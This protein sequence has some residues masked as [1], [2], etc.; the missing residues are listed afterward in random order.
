MLDALVR[1]FLYYPEPLPR[2]ARVP[3]YCGP[4]RE[5]WLSSALGDEINALYWEPPPGRPVLL[6]LHG[7]AQCIHEWALVREDL[8]GTETGMLLLDYP[9]YGKSTGQPREEG[10]YAAGRAG[11]EWLLERWP[12]RLVVVF[13]KSL[14]GGVAT[15]VAQDADLGALVLESTFTS[16]PAVARRL[17]PFLPEGAFPD[18]ERYDSLSKIGK[19]RCP[20]LVIHGTEDELIPFEQGRRLYEAA[21]QPKEFF[22][23]EGAGHNNVALVAG[24][25]YASRLRAFLDRHVVSGEAV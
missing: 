19:V 6:Y 12:A 7:N 21:P 11:L 16:V 24:E 15:E 8:E 4:A 18:T 3:G 20:V 13:G 5:V 17:I 1:R 10:L 25:G 22:P 9:G 2:D 14:G 23:V